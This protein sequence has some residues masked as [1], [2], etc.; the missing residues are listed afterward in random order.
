[1]CHFRNGGRGATLD[2]TV[3]QGAHI[4]A[5]LEGRGWSIAQLARETGIARESLSRI[6]NDREGLGPERGEKV[7]AVLGLPL[8]DVL[9]ERP[10]Q[11]VDEV[12]LARIENLAVE[13]LTILRGANG[14]QSV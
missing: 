13:I 4:R 9:L 7:A 5:L 12:Q 10:T 3:T 11:P 2:V 1:M 8:E 6:I 14:R